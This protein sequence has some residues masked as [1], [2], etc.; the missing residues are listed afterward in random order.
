MFKIN[1]TGVDHSWGVLSYPSSCGCTNILTSATIA[2]YSPCCSNTNCI[3]GFCQCQSGQSTG[4]CLLAP[5]GF[6]CT[7]DATC[8]SGRCAGNYC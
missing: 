6:N 7:T 5:S 4:M 2:D 8:A 1:S 3:S